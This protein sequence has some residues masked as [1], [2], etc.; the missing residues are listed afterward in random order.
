MGLLDPINSL[1]EIA[2]DILVC[3]PTA[4]RH[5]PPGTVLR[6]AGRPPFTVVLDREDDVRFTRTPLAAH[7]VMAGRVVVHPTVAGSGRLLWHDVLDAVTDLRAPARATRGTAQEQEHAV[8]AALKAAAVRQ[9]TVLR[10]H[11]IGWGWW[12]EL[13]NLHRTTQTDV[14]MVHH[15]ALSP[16]LTHLLRHC[17]HRV[18]TTHAGLLALHPPA[19]AAPGD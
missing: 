15:A 5:C 16:D 4:S 18:I 8:R 12:A 7:D 17:D 3:G 6:T 10:A 13:I 2:V 9:L 11:R 1:G 14:V 19:G